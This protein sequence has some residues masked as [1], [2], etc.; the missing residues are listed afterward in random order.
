MRRVV[1]L[2]R[3]GAGKSALARRLAAATGL[4]LTELDELFWSADATPLPRDRWAAIQDELVAAE[5][6][7]LDGD[8][9]PFD[10]LEPRLRAADTIIVLDFPLGVC[11]WRALRRSRE[12][13]VFWRWVICY[14]RR[15]LPGILAGISRCASADQYLLRHPREVER[16]LDEQR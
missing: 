13:L 8:L 5:T 3:G 1:I 11:L 16:F 14:R 9:G 2:G 15:S 7:I 6:W 4:P 12:S 10:V